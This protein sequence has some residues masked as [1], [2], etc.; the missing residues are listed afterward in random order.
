[1]SEQEINS[2]KEARNQSAKKKLAKID[3]MVEA[4]GAP[5]AQATKRDATVAPQAAPRTDQHGKPMAREVNGPRGLEPTR[6]GDW[7]S[8]GRCYDF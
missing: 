4:G 8:K 7:E 6:Y 5:D 2:G 3:I 1:M